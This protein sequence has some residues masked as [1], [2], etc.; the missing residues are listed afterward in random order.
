MSETDPVI[1]TVRALLAAAHLP[2]S[3][4]EIEAYAIGY[5][6]LR[7]GVEAL[8]AAP[9][10]RYL[11]PALRFQADPGPAADWAG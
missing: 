2:A 5:P 10:V 11:D 4:A 7:A 3:D 6:G 1:D 8:Y 9:E